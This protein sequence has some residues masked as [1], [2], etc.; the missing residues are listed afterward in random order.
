MSTEIERE[1][2]RKKERTR[3]M[4][5][6]NTRII[7]GKAVGWDGSSATWKSS[8]QSAATAAASLGCRS[9]A[10]A[11]TDT[12]TYRKPI[13]SVPIFLHPEQKGVV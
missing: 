10:A 6:I 8:A 5:M 12:P 1:R 11:G 4:Q 9:T 7:P 2:G 13:V 3:I